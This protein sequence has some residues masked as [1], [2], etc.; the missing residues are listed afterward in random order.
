MQERILIKLI[1]ITQYQV[2]MNWQHFKF[3]GS[4]VKVTSN[5][6]ENAY[7]WRKHTN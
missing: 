4:V 1:R 6:S 7:F 3:M 2:N 5:I